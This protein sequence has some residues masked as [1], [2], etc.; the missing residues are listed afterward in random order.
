MRFQRNESGGTEIKLS[1]SLLNGVDDNFVTESA[2]SHVDQVQIDQARDLLSVTHLSNGRV[3][4]G[5]CILSISDQTA[6]QSSRRSSDQCAFRR[7]IR[8]M[9]D[10]RA[11]G[12]SQR[13]AHS[14]IA[15]HVAARMTA[16]EQAREQQ[17]R[18]DQY[19]SSATRSAHLFTLHE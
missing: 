7:V 6:G 10:D 11:S 19:S 18:R 14:R 9:P 13:C 15:L 17:H 12:T 16:G 5:P 1:A 3:A 4:L 2:L 8:L